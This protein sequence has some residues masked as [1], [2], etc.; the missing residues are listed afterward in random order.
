MTG[1]GS[2]KHFFWL[3][4]SWGR[5]AWKMRLRCCDVGLALLLGLVA[6]A[7]AT[8]PADGPACG[9]GSSACFAQ[10]C[11]GN[12][13]MCT[14]GKCFG[15]CL[16]ANK[17]VYAQ[18]GLYNGG[19]A[20]NSAVSEHECKT[21]PAGRFSPTRT[22]TQTTH[23]ALSCEACPAGRY[24]DSVGKE[25][26][27]ACSTQHEVGGITCPDPVV[28]L[29][30]PAPTTEVSPPKCVMSPWSGWSP[31]VMDCGRDAASPT[32]KCTTFR[33]RAPL[34]QQS[35]A[36]KC[37]AVMDTRGCNGDAQHGCYD[38]AHSTARARD[39]GNAT[40]A[41]QCPSPPVVHYAT[42]V[43]TGYHDGAKVFYQCANGFHLSGRAEARCACD[44]GKP[45][46]WSAPP[47]CSMQEESPIGTPKHWVVNAAEIKDCN[48]DPNLHVA[49]DVQCNLET[50][51][52][53]GPVHSE[54][55][56]MTSHRSIRVLHIK[57]AKEH[58]H[59][60]CRYDKSSA[61]C[62]CCDCTRVTRATNGCPCGAAENFF[63]RAWQ[64]GATKY[65][66][67]FKPKPGTTTCEVRGELKR[68]G[69]ARGVADGDLYAE[70]TLAVRNGRLSF[71][72]TWTQP[73][74]VNCPDFGTTVPS[75]DMV[76]N[77]WEQHKVGSA[78]EV[79]ECG[80]IHF[81][82]AP[83][84]LDG[85]WRYTSWPAQESWDVNWKPPLKSMACSGSAASVAGVPSCSSLHKNTL[86]SMS[87]GPVCV[88]KYM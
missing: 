16:Q 37:D 3:T 15:V 77:L 39:H 11:G 72:G 1:F 59:H 69:W 84:R 43:S 17:L 81:F 42:H 14:E 88:A 5:P 67:S 44:A 6:K 26:C 56:G 24:Q 29:T 27:K 52:C 46:A 28:A 54:C 83:N 32:C 71:A 80:F 73:S 87:G 38:A 41:G 49:T 30:S 63:N 70:G 48:C 4:A 65:W 62:R 75:P 20:C 45:C 61:A 7:S 25:G 55:D 66:W 13:G 18:S 74:D 22:S 76:W 19:D 36:S 10:Y 78:R 79:H 33:S 47:V 64:M 60:K 51:K 2:T 82:I 31:C 53:G 12:H 9:M 57:G 8:V 23:G 68:E 21:C 40:P 34:E 58:R 35:P 86:F 85:E 50:H